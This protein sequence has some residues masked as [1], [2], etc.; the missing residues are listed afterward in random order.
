MLL[1]TVGSSPRYGSLIEQG[2]RTA[3]NYMTRLAGFLTVEKLTVLMY[4]MYMNRV[5]SQ[6]MECCC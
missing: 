1:I 6:K 2:T 5:R 3:G 4:T